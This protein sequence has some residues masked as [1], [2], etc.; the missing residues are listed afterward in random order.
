MIKQ[1]ETV[2]SPE[3]VLIR[4]DQT[5][6]T[7]LGNSRV[8]RES[9]TT[10]KILGTMWDSNKDTLTINF[11]EMLSLQELLEIPFLT[12]RVLLSSVAKVFDPMGLISPS[13]I[14]MKILFQNLCKNGVDWD[15]PVDSGTQKAWDLS[16]KD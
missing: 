4:D 5:G 13:I 1:K 15:D 6:D 3:P 16:L 2:V 12:K 10:G 14:L 9:E 8:E 11:E 7:N